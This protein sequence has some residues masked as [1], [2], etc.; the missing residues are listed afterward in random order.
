MFLRTFI[1]AYVFEGE[2]EAGVFPLDDSNLAK[3]TSADDSQ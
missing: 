3:S 1:F 2:R